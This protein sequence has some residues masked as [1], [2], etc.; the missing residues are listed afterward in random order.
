MKAIGLVAAHRSD[1]SDSS[2]VSGHRSR[3]MVESM[4]TG[5]SMDTGLSL[6]AG[7]FRAAAGWSV[8]TPVQE[9]WVQEQ[10][11]APPLPP[12]ELPPLP[13]D[14]P[15]LPGSIPDRR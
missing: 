4:P 7:P 12:D 9:Q 2:Y 14:A 10:W 15:P 6:D 5:L 11:T 3:S 8:S 13:P 1:P